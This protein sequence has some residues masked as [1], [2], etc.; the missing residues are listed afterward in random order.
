LAAEALGVAPRVAVLPAWMMKTLGLVVPMMR[1]LAEMLYQ[2]D[3]DYVFDSSK[4]ERRFS[5]TPTPYAE[6]IRASIRAP[7]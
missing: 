1:E 3:S 7:L 5:F 4:F 6:G 2:N